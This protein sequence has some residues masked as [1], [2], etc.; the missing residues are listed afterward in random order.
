MLNK[1]FDLIYCIN[2]DTRKDRWEDSQKEFK[3]LDLKVER[4]SG[5]VYTETSDPFWNRCIGCH[6]SHL[7]ILKLAKSLNKS[8][9]IFEDDIKFI[10]NY[11]EV[12]NKSLEELPEDFDMF[13][14]GGNI[15][16]KI[17][18]VSDHLGKL[19]HA[20][21]TH[22]YG[23]NINFINKILEKEEEFYTKRIDLIYADELIPFNNCYITIP[24]VS[25]QRPNF[26]DIEGKNVS[27]DAW[28]EE[29]FYSNLVRK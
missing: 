18:Q 13:Y 29:R 25:I 20:Q 11:S 10:N 17:Y 14:L 27:Y 28:M 6:L 8:V 4:F 9:F 21:S 7:A 23:V 26:S 22:A 19:T 15:C 2:L 5:I 12:L 1:F 3:K 24:M 16:N